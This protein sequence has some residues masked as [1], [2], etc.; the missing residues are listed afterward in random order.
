MEYKKSKVTPSFVEL[1]NIERQRIARDLHDCTIQDLTMLIHKVELAS[2]YIDCDTNLAKLE[3]YHMIK[4]IRTI[5]DDMRDIVFNL[6][7]MQ[8]DDLGFTDAINSLFDV[9][10]EETEIKILSNVKIVNLMSK[11]LSVSMYQIIQEICKNAIK[12]SNA[13]MLKI[14]ISENDLE[15]KIQIEDDG[16]GFELPSKNEANKHFGL[17]I[18]KERILLLKGNIRIDSTSGMGTKVIISVPI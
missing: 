14:D 6:R 17:L 4:N 15:F 18:V 2:K 10:Q 12:H 7:P 3:L 1:Q 9:L 16:I 5:I 8:I 11:E 13:R